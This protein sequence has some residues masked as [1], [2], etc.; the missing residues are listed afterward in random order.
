MNGV[1]TPNPG[2]STVSLRSQA[3]PRHPNLHQDPQ[4]L[5]HSI[6]IRSSR[7]L[8]AT[9]LKPWLLLQSSHHTP[10][11][12]RGQDKPHRLH[13]DQILSIQPSLTMSTA[14]AFNQVFSISEARVPEG[15]LWSSAVPRLSSLF[16]PPHRCQ[17]TVI[18][19]RIATCAGTLDGLTSSLLLTVLAAHAPA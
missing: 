3:H 12:T 11:P 16:F 14:T 8:P 4:R 13:L 5:L 19:C 6:R 7:S 9:G 17:T 18:K 15:P 2:A 1:R 10:H